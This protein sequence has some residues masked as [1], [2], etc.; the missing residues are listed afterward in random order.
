MKNT[1]EYG[2]E[3]IEECEVIIEKSKS[4]HTELNIVK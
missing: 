4:W 3:I 1:N 2:F